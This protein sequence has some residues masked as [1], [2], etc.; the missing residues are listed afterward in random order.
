ME[1]RCFYRPTQVVFA[2]P[3]NAGQ[4]LSGIAYQDEIICGCCGGVFEIADVIEMAHEDGIKCA[5]H[6]YHSWNDIA[7]EI[8]G[9]ELPEGLERNSDYKICEVFVEDSFL[10][11][12]EEEAM[13]LANDW[14]DKM[15]TPSIN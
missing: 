7:D 15:V 5:I 8:V 6:Q 12:E 14:A 13:S 11:E 2:D 3:D 9:G 4:W 1:Q 10:L